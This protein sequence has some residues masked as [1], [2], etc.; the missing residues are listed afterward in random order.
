MPGAWY[1]CVDA[2][3][4]TVHADRSGWRSRSVSHSVAVG[5]SLSTARRD[6]V[7][8]LLLFFFFSFNLLLFCAVFKLS[9]ERT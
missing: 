1:T 2:S 6:R 9:D 3:A 7:G 8:D 5:E 4:V